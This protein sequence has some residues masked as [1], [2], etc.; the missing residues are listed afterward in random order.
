M[1]EL[2]TIQDIQ[3]ALEPLKRQLDNIS[4]G[5]ISQQNLTVDELSEYIKTPKSTIYQ[6]IN[7][8]PGGKKV[9]GKWLF[10]RSIIDRWLSE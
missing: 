10:K 3:K 4:A 7:E 6:K 2:P 8:I 5:V 1:I 9:F